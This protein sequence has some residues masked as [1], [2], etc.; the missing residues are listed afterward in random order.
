MR[1]RHILTPLVIA[2]AGLPG[3]GKSTLARELCER[4]SLS[5]VDRDALRAAMFPDCRYTEAE[6]KA[7]ERAVKDAVTA[8]CAA[9]H[10]TLIDGMTFGR[11]SVREEFV[12][13]ASGCGARFV[14]LW[15]DCPAAVARA[16][17]ASDHTHVAADRV[18]GLV[19]RAAGYFE[20]PGLA[21]LRID[22]L[23]PR[24]DVVE[25]ACK[26]VTT[27]LINEDQHERY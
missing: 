12:A 15:L 17:V 18:P 4:F 3:A 6:K 11:R 2:L 20:A 26:L 23:L 21:A 27:L 10:N 5:L 22:G 16:R 9:A 25:Q 24:A 1:N 7:A 13:H 14:V 19:D 8:N